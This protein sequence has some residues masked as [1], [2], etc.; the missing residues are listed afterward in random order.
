MM[1][2]ESTKLSEAIRTKI[3]PRMMHIHAVSHIKTYTCT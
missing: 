1:N 3:V 2:E